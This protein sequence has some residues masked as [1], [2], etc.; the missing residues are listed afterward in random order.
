MLFLSLADETRHA[1][2]PSLVGIGGPRRRMLI[3]GLAGGF[4]EEHDEAGEPKLASPALTGAG[5]DGPD[6]SPSVYHPVPHRSTNDG[7][8]GVEF[9]LLDHPGRVDQGTPLQDPT[10]SGVQGRQC[11]QTWLQSRMGGPLGQPGPQ[12]ACGGPGRP[13]KGR[14]DRTRRPHLSPRQSSAGGMWALIP[15]ESTT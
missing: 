7:V 12:T 2:N 5:R 14:D 1:G 11:A 4:R 6:K 9:P 3:E 13:H 10:P 8:S 15:N